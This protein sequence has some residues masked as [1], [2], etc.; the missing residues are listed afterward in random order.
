MYM[1]PLFT[2]CLLLTLARLSAQQPAPAAANFTT[3]REGEGIRFT[4]QAP[5]LAAPVAGAPPAFYTYYWEFGDGGFSFEERPLH[6]YA[7][8]KTV[9]PLLM[10]TAHYD[11]TNSPPPSYAGQM[12]A[13]ASKSPSEMPDVF[14]KDRYAIALKA[15]RQ[16]RAGEEMVVIISY[17]NLSKINTDGR[18]HL[19]YN[20]KKF[21]NRHFDYVNARAHFGEVPD[22]I[23]ATDSND[24]GAGW[25]DASVSAAGAAGLLAWTAPP[26]PGDELLATA[27]KQFRSEEIWR[28]GWLA[29][30]EKRNLFVSLRGTADML[31]DTSAI[32]HLRGVFEPLDPAVPAEEFTL[33]IEI[34]GSHDPNLIAV[35]EH[36]VNF[37]NIEQQDIEYKVR[38]QNNGEGPARRIQLTV[39]IPEGLNAAQMRPLSW[40][41]ECPICP[42]SLSPFSCLDTATTKDALIFTF[43]NIYLPGS[44]QRGVTDYDSTQGFVRY[45]IEPNRK[46]AK[47]AFRSQAEIVFDKNPPI[48]TNFSK[49]RFKPGLSPGLKAGYALAPDEPSQGYFFMGMSLSPYSSWKVYPQVELLTGLKGQTAFDEQ[50]VTEEPISPPDGADFYTDTIYTATLNGSSS[51]VSLELPVLLRKNFTGF[52]GAGIGG[53]IRAVIN[54]EQTTLTQSGVIYSYVW[55]ADGFMP[56]PDF[57]PQDL[58]AVTVTDSDKT[59]DV[60]YS[61][62]GDLTFG[63][64]R[65]GLNLGVRGGWVFL[66]KATPFVQVSLEYKL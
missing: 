4:P 23:G 31:R 66:K 21:P 2:L 14:P 53:S 65:S 34:V 33:E 24:D 3:L 17:R 8:D 37:R 45:R 26:P 41:P 46:M 32:I 36:K 27:R 13:S 25:T 43:R 6:H 11:D 38:F 59:L 12:Y 29:T 44:R 62:F 22:A 18:L 30:G 57:P 19:F 42:D 35:S 28:T 1:K 48:R 39:R 10:A 51:F 20:E 16:P 60:R 15:Q 52:F 56:N 9:S 47:L 55:G 50:S 49:T 40:Y 5:P 61:A 54:N 63:K 7:A 64:V 58:P